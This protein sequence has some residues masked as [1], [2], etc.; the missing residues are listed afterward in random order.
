MKKRIGI[1][2]SLGVLSLTA[3]LSLSSGSAQQTAAACNLKAPSSPV[4][5]N[6]FGF[7]FPMMEYYFKAAEACGKGNISVRTSFLQP[8]QYET[9]VNTALA[10]GTS[11]YQILHVN[12]RLVAEWGN[13][14]WLAPLNTLIAKYKKQYA[15]DDISD[16]LIA[17]TTLN[18]RQYALP[19]N[20]NTQ[21]QFYR[22]DIFADLNIKPARNL[23]ELSSVLAA[24]KKANKTR[25]PMAL[26]LGG[27]GLAGEF[28]SNYA[29]LGG[30]WFDANRK[31]IFNNA[32]GVKAA[33]ALR[34]WLEFMPPAVLNYTN[35]DVMVGLQQG[36]IALSKIWITRAAA[37]EDEKVSRVV[38]K[39][40]Y[41]PAF[42]FVANGPGANTAEGDA[43]AIAASSKVD[44][45]L[46]FRI[47]MEMLGKQNQSNA[48]NLGM[49]SRD[50]IATNPSLVAKNRSWI[51]AAANARQAVP[52]RPA[53]A[54]QGIANTILGNELRLALANK[55]DLKV[56][57]DTAAKKVEDEM[58]VQGFYR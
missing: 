25:F 5:I 35:D 13:K 58:R 32:N 43:L 38:G 15:L 1:G 17:N 20:F 50:S 40:D 52:L 47:M 7:R 37:M 53:V 34:D 30:V 11:P 48:A 39:I 19:V 23:E 22:K 54:Y 33:Q 42:K 21:V 49:V 3:A 31:P 8:A 26:A 29:A 28:H 10:T 14:G 57:L 9:Q 27:G 56:A 4:T 24:L 36:D 51:A 16:K 6:V 18:G 46:V 44:V 55:T 12:P 41:A 2:L 45:D